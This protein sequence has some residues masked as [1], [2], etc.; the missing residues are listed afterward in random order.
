MCSRILATH[1]RRKGS[2]E[3]VQAEKYTFSYISGSHK[4]FS[5]PL[6]NYS[7]AVVTNALSFLRRPGGGCET[8][9][10]KWGPTVR[11][12]DLSFEY[13]W[14]FSDSESVVQVVVGSA[15]FPVLF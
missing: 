5:F 4:E 15:I 9:G 2:A 11:H 7:F 3:R 12:T 10:I 1:T 8:D 6:R 13:K 14:A